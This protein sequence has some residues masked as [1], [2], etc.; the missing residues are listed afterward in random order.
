[1]NATLNLEGAAALLNI[2]PATAQEMVAAGKIPGA[3]IGRARVF[4]GDDLIEWLRGEIKAQVEKRKEKT[5]TGEPNVVFVQRKPK[6][7]RKPVPKLNKVK[8]LY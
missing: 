8:C 3:K 4:P 5:A 6:S 2:S 1:M 7:R